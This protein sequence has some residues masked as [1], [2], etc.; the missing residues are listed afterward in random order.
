MNIE[1]VNVNFAFIKATQGTQS[2]DV[3]YFQNKS[4][5]KQAKITH[6]AYHFFVASKDP[7]AQANLFSKVVQL[8]KG[9]LPPV[10]D[11]EKA[12][13]QS[14]Y[15][16]RKNLKTWLTLI[17]RRYAVK[18]IIYTN[19][20]F[21]KKYLEGY[22]DNNPIWIAHYTKLN[23]PNLEKEWTFWQLSEEAN[24]NGI[25]GKVDFNVF[26]GSPEEFEHLKIK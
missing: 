3:Q 1:G 7:V 2:I 6:G 16:I 9:D 13:N 15:K 12:Y 21:Y 11:I 10:V 14:G 18:P 17:E 25:K 19:V 4:R 22:F 26:N 23:E 5:V 8:H 24:V 20:D